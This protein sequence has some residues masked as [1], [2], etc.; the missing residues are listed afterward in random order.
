MSDIHDF[1]PDRAAPDRDDAEDLGGLWQ[2]AADPPPT[3]IPAERLARRWR[4]QL[5]LVTGLEI[6]V[7]I[8]LAAW[9]LDAIQRRPTGVELVLWVNAWTLAAVV[10]IYALWN[11]RGLWRPLGESTPRFLEQWRERCRRGLRTVS[12]VRAVV[13]FEIAFLTTLLIVSGKGR[14]SSFVT[15]GAIGLAYHLW[16]VLFERSCQRDL[17]SIS[18]LEADLRAESTGPQGYADVVAEADPP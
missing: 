1:G 14:L 5:W 18:E 8:G 17:A 15:L 9:T 10:M 13:A 3:T 12:F 7:L 6:G 4:Q 2:A 11:R 16:S